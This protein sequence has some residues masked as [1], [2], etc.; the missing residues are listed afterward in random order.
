MPRELAVSCGLSRLAS[1]GFAD[2]TLIAAGM[3]GLVF[4]LDSRFI[5]KIWPGAPNARLD[6]LTRLQA[7]Y[8]ALA[9][10]HLPFMTPYIEQIVP[11]DM[12]TVTV[13]RA[14]PGIQLR[15]ATT[16]EGRGVQESTVD[17]LTT[18]LRGLA[19]VAPSTDLAGV[20]VLGEAEPLAR[21]DRPWSE[22]VVALLER[23]V[24][25]FGGQLRESVPGFFEQFNNL[26]GRLGSVTHST[27]SVIHGDLV[28]PNVLV[29][30]HERPLAVVDFGFLSTIGDPAFDAA[31]CA[32]TFDMYSANA[33]ATRDLLTRELASRLNYNLEVLTL[34]QAAYAVATSNVYDADGRD[35]HFAWCVKQLQRSDVA[36]L[37]RK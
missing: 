31:V 5:G 3:E 34:Y 26:S 37:L 15:S 7:F 2:A 11:L 1:L 32:S 18:V 27:S 12:A 17:C 6:M 13:E 14:L 33:D 8:S 4:R 10:Q 29:D 9:R 16:V 36:R 22:S 24:A 20:P 25:Q 23:R 21:L 35:G 19:S 30:A 28:P